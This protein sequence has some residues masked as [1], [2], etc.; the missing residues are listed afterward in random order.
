MSQS[1]IV[2]AS[3]SCEIAERVRITMGARAE[4]RAGWRAFRAAEVVHVVAP[5]AELSPV[6]VRLFASRASAIWTPLSP[7]E[8]LPWWTRT[9]DRI[10]LSS[11][12][13][14]TAWSAFV[15][16]GRLS[17]APEGPGFSVALTAIYAEVS[18]LRRGR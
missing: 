15:P 13:E 3:A 1:R 18:A 10:V 6:V 14:A 12:V 8:P 2:V 5:L 9:F 11:Q 17:I 16:F 7:P 4:S